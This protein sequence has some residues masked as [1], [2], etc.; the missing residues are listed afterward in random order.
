[1]ELVSRLARSPELETGQAEILVV[2]N[3]SD[4]PLPEF[5]RDPPQ[6]VRLISRLENGGF[7]VVV[8]AGWRVSRGNWILLINPDV[9]VPDGWLGRILSRLGDQTSPAP[10]G[11]AAPAGVVGF[12]LRNPDGS[13]QHSVGAFPSLA[14]AFWEQLI[15]RSRRKYQ[16][17]WRTKSGPVDWVT[18]ACALV[19]VQ[20]LEALGGLDED[21][22]LY[23]EEVALCRSAWKLGWRVEYDPEPSVE[24]VHLRPL[25][26]RALNPRM[27]VITRHSKLL[28]FRKHLPR[29]QFLALCGIVATEARTR[30]AWA[31]LWGRVEERRAWDAIAFVERQL[32]QGKPLVGRDVL[33]LADSILDSP[34][35][36][37][38]SPLPRRSTTLG[39]EDP[40]AETR[41]GP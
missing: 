35:G 41:Q 19:K 4:G 27:R 13:R 37:P 38:V 17:V 15:P 22:F 39:A 20:L 7:A 34:G 31:R 29:W 14:R 21:F 10:R 33:A 12:A 2:D 18:G 3:A 25:Q 6:G 26:N 32:R 9:V 8:N 30:S 1:V 23:Y 36:Q 40:R 5:F 11:S 28:Y 24:V 16:A